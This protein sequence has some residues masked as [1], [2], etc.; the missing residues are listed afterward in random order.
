MTDK[1]H[2]AYLSV[3]DYGDFINTYFASKRFVAS[4]G[5][6][7]PALAEVV[8]LKLAITAQADLNNEDDHLHSEYFS[9]KTGIPLQSV[10]F[11]LGGGI[12]LIQEK[13][14]N[15]SDFN[16]GLA[17]DFS[18]RFLLPASFRSMLSFSGQYAS[19]RT[20]SG[21]IA[22]FVPVNSKSYGDILKANLS[23]ISV[24]SLDYSAR[25]HNTFSVS[26]SMAY[27]I[28][29]DLGTYE[30]HPVTA[31]SGGHFLG[32]EF[33]AQVFWS[34]VSDLRANLGGGVFLPAMGNAASD[35]DPLWRIQ[36]GLVFAL[37]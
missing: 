29:N 12:Q 34:P 27:F 3:L 1:D 33:F 11:E 26:A 32:G 10:M 14:N 5:W 7:H 24:L 23:G 13:V 17:V 25:I 21:S 9:F 18:A 2:D 15:K 36:L 19:G 30:G 28:R 6:E 16:I 4:L 20:E 35:A 22:A 37:Y 31:G 8:P